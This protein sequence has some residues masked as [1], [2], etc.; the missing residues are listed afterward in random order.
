MKGF[1]I[2]LLKIGEL[3]IQTYDNSIF[4]LNKPAEEIIILV[5]GKKVCYI[6]QIIS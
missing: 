6:N 3:L 1:W 5:G 2:P 4:V